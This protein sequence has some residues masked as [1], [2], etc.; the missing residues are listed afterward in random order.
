MR[1]FWEKIF[2]PHCCGWE[3]L[4]LSIF[5][6]IEFLVYK[7]H[8]RLS[9]H[10]LFPGCEEKSLSLSFSSPYL[11]TWD[12][13]YGLNG[14]KIVWQIFAVL[15]F[16]CRICFWLT[17]FCNPQEKNEGLDVAFVAFFHLEHCKLWA[18]P[19]IPLF[20]NISCGS[21]SSSYSSSSSSSSPSWS[22]MWGRIVS[23]LRRR[24]EWRERPVTPPLV[25]L[26]H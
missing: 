26:V 16:V 18:W 15:E 12:T 14:P 3:N 10:A 8:H 5:C 9:I 13:F 1:R 24:P 4:F 2:F 11:K 19:R 25:L 21:V 7:R 20:V 23:V 6:Q 17:L 22:Y